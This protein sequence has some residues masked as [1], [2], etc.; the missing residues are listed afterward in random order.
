MMRV[1]SVPVIG[2]Q[3]HLVVL[4]PPS[5]LLLL[6]LLQAEEFAGFLS[7]VLRWTPESR[8]TAADL[9]K[10]PWLQKDDGSLEAEW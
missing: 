3:Q 6:L 8:A 5:L 10:H 4:F 1:N 9:L 2:L 7:E